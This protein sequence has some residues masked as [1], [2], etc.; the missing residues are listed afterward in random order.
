VLVEPCPECGAKVW[1]AELWM[2]EKT[3]QNAQADAHSELECPVLVDSTA[4]RAST[5]SG[6][7]LEPTPAGVS[8]KSVRKPA[9]VRQAKWR[10]RR[11]EAATLRAA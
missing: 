1:F 4:F 8:T 5:L 10:A 3:Y 6:T 7:G 9:S 2:G 11:K